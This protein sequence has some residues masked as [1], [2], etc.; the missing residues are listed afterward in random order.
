MP[1]VRSNAPVVAGTLRDLARTFPGEINRAVRGAGLRL[2]DRMR[3][4]V[5]D[6]RPPLS[7]RP[8]D[9]LTVRLRS[10]TDPKGYGGMLNKTITSQP[11]GSGV[12]VGWPVGLTQWAEAFQTAE[13]RMTTPAERRR[14]YVKGLQ[15]QP[16]YNRPARPVMEPFS[17]ATSTWFPAFEADVRKRIARRLAKAG[18]R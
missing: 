4:D 17:R 14:I 5:R 3:K 1:S 10:A 16:E 18:A 7:F 9:T 8:L 13:R 2:R 6:G 11:T 15:A 12:T